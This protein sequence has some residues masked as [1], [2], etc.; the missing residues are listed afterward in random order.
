M[1]LLF[2]INAM[3]RALAMKSCYTKVNNTN[4]VNRGYLFKYSLLEFSKNL[5]LQE[6]ITLNEC[7]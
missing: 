3:V 5:E 2:L 7:A 1:H 6:F 4:V